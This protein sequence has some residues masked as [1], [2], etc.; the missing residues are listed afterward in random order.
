MVDAAAGGR[1]EEPLPPAAPPRSGVA[2]A[3]LRHVFLS[4]YFVLYLSVAYFLILAPILPNFASLDNI[5]LNIVGNAWPLLPV[6][7]GQTVVLI[8][9]GIDLS[10][11]AIMAITSLV[12]AALM[13]SRAS[14][15]QFDKSALWGWL[16]TPAGGPFS[17]SPLAVPVG[18]TAM[19]VVGALI[20][21]FNGLAIA[22][23]RMPAFMVTL[24]TSMFMASFAIWLTQSYNIAAL[25]GAYVAIGKDGLF[26]IP[27]A[28]VVALG[29]ALV[30]HVLLTRMI[31]G[32]WMYATGTNETAA[33]VSGV[34]VMRTIVLAYVVSAVCAAIGAILFSARLEA[35]RPTLGG[36]TFLLDVIAATVIGGTSLFGGKG[37]VM[38]TI[39]GVLF[40]ALLSNSLSL[41]N[42]SP[43]VIDTVRG[44]FILVVI[45]LDVVRRRFETVGPR[46]MQT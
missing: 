38:W 11:G 40:F 25:P 7:I 10:Q 2:G 3:V 14:E 39:F 41:M 36:G 33:L 19:L 16:L 4:E 26:G 34:P 35:G 8:V 17:Q 28:M 45:T 30:V 22:R 12:G 24:V 32:R 13:T 18:I 15:V 1:M 44:S 5:T 42:L 46:A 20:G 6:A 29:V 23:L 9:K 31:V 27:Y 37:K 43:F 21:L